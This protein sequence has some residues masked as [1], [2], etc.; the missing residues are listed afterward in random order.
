MALN[1]LDGSPEVP[2]LKK[3]RDAW[4]KVADDAKAEL[5]RTERRLRVHE[6]LS[7]SVVAVPK[8][9]RPKSKKARRRSN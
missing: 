8:W 6:Q 5:E 9:A 1:D 2:K 4:K 7:Q 3:E